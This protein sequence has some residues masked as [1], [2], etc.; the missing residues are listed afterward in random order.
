MMSILSSFASCSSSIILPRMPFMFICKILSSEGFFFE[1][2]FGLAFGCVGCL[3][4]L[5]R[6][7]FVGRDFGFVV[8]IAFGFG[9]A[10]VVVIVLFV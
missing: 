10:A 4:V 9:I 7:V 8:A 5:L 6:V 1:S 3:F 2:G